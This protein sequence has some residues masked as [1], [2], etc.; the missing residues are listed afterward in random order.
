MGELMAQNVC[1]LPI[2]MPDEAID[3]EIRHTVAHMKQLSGCE[4]KVSE[5]QSQGKPPQ[6]EILNPQGSNHIVVEY[7]PDDDYEPFTVFFAFQHRHMRDEN[8]ILQYVHEIICG[9]R[10]SIEYFRE[11]KPRFGGE[12]TAEALKDL[13]YE[14]LERE[15]GY[16]GSVRLIDCADAFKVRGWNSASD[17]DAVF[18]T[19][20]N[21]A[22]EIVRRNIT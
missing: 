1:H 17:F 2:E 12:I 13:S 5:N 7:D 20:E 3:L 16:Y 19:D 4:I 15:T 14:A 22:V 18:V 8:D 9:N 10:F 6:V 21:G 11:G